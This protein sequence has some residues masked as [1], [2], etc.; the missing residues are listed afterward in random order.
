MKTPALSSPLRSVRHGKLEETCY[1][2]RLASGMTLR[3]VPRK[4]HSRTFAILATD[5][6]SIDRELVLEGGDRLTLPAGTAHF[7]EHCLFAR[8]GED[9]CELLAERGA[10]ANAATGFTT[11]S[12]I[13]SCPEGFLENLDL[14][15]DFVQEPRFAEDTVRKERE[16][17]LQEIGTYSDNAD[18][19]QFLDLLRIVYRTHPVRDNIAGTRESL[20]D[21]TPTLLATTH[22]HAYHP[23]RLGLFVVGNVDPEAVVQALAGRSDPP[24]LGL[25]TIPVRGQSSHN[26]EII[27]S[28]SEMETFLAVAHPR[29]LMAF[30]DS[31]PSSCAR[32]QARREAATTLLLDL[33]FGK[34]SDLHTRLYD[35]GLIDDSF[36]ATHNA[37]RSFA[38]TVIGGDTKDPVATRDALLDALETIAQEGLSRKDFLRLKDKTLGSTLLAFDSVEATAYTLLHQHLRGGELEDTL[39]A[40]EELELADVEARARE[41]LVRE[42]CATSIGWPLARRRV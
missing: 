41:H 30:K 19:C 6:G 16:I 37:D 22:S 10:T 13:L 4:G 9:V 40:L 24:L 12:F 23:A 2:A 1:Q 39:V 28:R 5:F 33:A 20:A 27:P 35:M 29:L 18:W 32:E 38:F 26:E 31:P 21:I 36:A 8:D 3:I 42:R 17:I 14:L 34:S 15:L 25:S 11:T 7:L